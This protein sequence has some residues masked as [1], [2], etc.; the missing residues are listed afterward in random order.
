M[1]NLVLYFLNLCVS[2][3][4]GVN[5][6]HVLEIKRNKKIKFASGDTL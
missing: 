2:C 6:I 4:V 1:Y 5:G 3:V